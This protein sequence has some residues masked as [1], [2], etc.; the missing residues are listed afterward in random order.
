[1]WIFVVDEN[2]EVVL[3]G[4][5][6]ELIIVGLFVLKGYLNNFEKIVKVFFELDG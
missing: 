2:G 1:M 5:E 6:G 4:M 3:N